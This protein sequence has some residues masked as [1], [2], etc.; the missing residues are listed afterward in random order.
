VNESGVKISSGKGGMG[1][2]A[3]TRLEEIQRAEWR[4]L[5]MPEILWVNRVR[6]FGLL[7]ID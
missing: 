7:I 3:A 2:L 4:D 5:G 1:M 6:H